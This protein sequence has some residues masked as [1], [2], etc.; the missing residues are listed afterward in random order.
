[1]AQSR[2]QLGPCCKVPLGREGPP[3][4][5]SIRLPRPVAPA[6]LALLAAASLAGCASTPEIGTDVAMAGM[7]NAELALRDSMRAVDAEMGKL[8]TLR[9]ASATGPAGTGPVVPG[10]LQKVVTF[11][12]SGTLEDGVRK[13]AGDV[14]YAVSVV[15]PARGQAPVVVG[16]R[17]TAAPVI[18]AFQALGAAG[19]TR[20]DVR[21]DP[22]LRQV[23]VIYRP[24]GP[25][26]LTS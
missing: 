26:G 16:V 24:D 5:R 3:M 23:R 4:T 10:E 22:A 25:G 1:M 19:G 11:T 6:S 7:P 8:G 12:W 13:L 14:G 17:T 18:E 15:P 21:V 20:A 9:L 2:I